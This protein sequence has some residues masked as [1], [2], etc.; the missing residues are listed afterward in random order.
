MIYVYGAD[1]FDSSPSS[2]SLARALK[3]AGF[4]LSEMQHVNSPNDIPDNSWVISFGTGGLQA[5]VPD[6]PKI[7]DVR[8]QL[9]SM[10]CRDD[11]LV[12]PTYAPG[13]L[14]RNPELM[15]Q[16][17]DDLELFKAVTTLG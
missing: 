10:D 11:V 14:Y 2:Q 8:G 9:C 17:K 1:P 16:W 12:L 4:K 7:G 5:L 15:R 6:N 13:Y 3:D